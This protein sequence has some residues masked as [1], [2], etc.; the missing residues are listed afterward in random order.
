MADHDAL[1]ATRVRFPGLSNDLEN[2]FSNRGA[3]HSRGSSLSIEEGQ[4]IERSLHKPPPPSEE[5]TVGLEI[6]QAF[7]DCKLGKQTTK[8]F[9]V[10]RVF[11]ALLPI[12]GVVMPPVDEYH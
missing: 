11:A 8:R 6:A 4:V 7:G 12:I 3:R 9:H 5:D 2:C 1:R 10:A